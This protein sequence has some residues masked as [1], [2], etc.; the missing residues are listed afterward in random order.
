MHYYSFNIGDYIKHTMH[1]SADEDLAYR[2]LLDM[3]YDTETPIPTAIPLLS[4]RLRLGI[5]IVESVLNEF[6]E[7][8]D[9]GYKNRRA[10]A[11]I[12]D[13][14]AYIGKQRSNG[15]LGGRP[16][17]TQAKPTAN[18]SQTQAK[19][20]KSLTN[21]QQPTNINQEIKTTRVTAYACP[22][23]VGLD[24]WA[25]FLLARKAKRAAVTDG[26]IR[27]IASEANKAGWTL[28]QALTEIIA[29]GWA[30]FKAEW[31]QKDA[32][33]QDATA[34]AARTMFNF[35]KEQQHEYDITPAT[36]RLD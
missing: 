20:K 15:K 17:K 28:E 7:K 12:A 13:Y 26:V 6:F 10:D 22:D 32:K 36:I 1:L 2:R 29:R 21:N 31:V 16:R 30:G 14:H 5:D 9:E 8:T 35:G 25:G 18:P 27:S 3:Y 23:G 24:T 34:N 11:E 33:V 4:R 19:P